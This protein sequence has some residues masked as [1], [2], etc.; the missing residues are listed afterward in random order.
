MRRSLKRYTLLGG[1]IAAFAATPSTASA[2]Y[3]FSSCATPGVCGKVEAFFT[4]ALLS[5][6]L[7]N[8]DNSVGSALFSAQLIFTS[9]LNPGTPGSAFSNTATASLS[10][11][12]AAIG[13]TPA[14]SWSFTGLGGSNV[15]DLNTFFSV[16]IEGD[17]ASGY[18]AGA[19]DT[20]NGTWITSSGY[21]E[22]TAD[23]SGVIGANGSNNITGL[24]FCTDVDCASGPAVEATPEPGTLILLATGMAGMLAL[25]WRRRRSAVTATA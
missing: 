10:G 20:E 8:N 12:V 14:N 15:L 9:A 13:A 16:F 7:S 1:A 3:Q 6:R 2:Q 11:G 24:S 22:F 23:L 19:G 17:A 18:R 5:V 4:G 25:G 21:V